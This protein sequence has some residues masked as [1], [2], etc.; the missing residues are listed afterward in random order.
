MRAKLTYEEETDFPVFYGIQFFSVYRALQILQ[1]LSGKKRNGFLAAKQR[2]KYGQKNTYDYGAGEWKIKGKI[3]LFDSD[4]S[5]KF[6][7]PR[8]LRTD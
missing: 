6:A 3:F 8:N 4:I 1:V 5:G 7:Q 2:K